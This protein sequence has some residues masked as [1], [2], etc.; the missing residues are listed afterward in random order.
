MWKTAVQNRTSHSSSSIAA[1][2]SWL[3]LHEITRK[4]QVSSE[5]LLQQELSLSMNFLF[6]EHLH[7]HHFH[8]FISCVAVTTPGQNHV[9]RTRISA[10]LLQG[11]PAVAAPWIPDVVLLGSFIHS[12][13]WVRKSKLKV[14]WLLH[15][16]GADPFSGQGRIVLQG[17]FS[18]I[19][20]VLC[21]LH[22]Y[23]LSRELPCFSAECLGDGCGHLSSLFAWICLTGQHC[24]VKLGDINEGSH[25]FFLFFFS[26]FFFFPFFFSL[27]PLTCNTLQFLFVSLLV[28]GILIF[29]P[30]KRS[31]FNSC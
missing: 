2:E 26:F 14:Q 16:V 11:S 5:K 8:E 17:L 21:K 4:S 19:S 31:I 7:K 20:V 18:L 30:N 24:L 12:C 27:L 29:S 3:E 15:R 23:P 25:Y 22:K 28:K 6:R 1:Q 13:C 10:S 9:W